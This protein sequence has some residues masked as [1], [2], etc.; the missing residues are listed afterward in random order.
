MEAVVRTGIA[1]KSLGAISVYGLFI[2]NT[3]KKRFCGF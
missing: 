3:V 1:S 2:K